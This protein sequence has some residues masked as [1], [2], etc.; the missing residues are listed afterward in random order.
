MS[1]DP[2]EKFRQLLNENHLFP[3]KYTHKIIGK[4]SPLFLDSIIEFEKKFIGLIRTQERKSASGAHLSLTYEY[5]AA[6]AEE[7]VQLSVE[8]HKINDVIYVL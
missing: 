6:N 1:H 4:N 2:Y 8:S 3:G 5:L 7:V